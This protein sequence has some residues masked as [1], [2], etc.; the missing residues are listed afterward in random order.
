VRIIYEI[1]LSRTMAHLRVTLPRADSKLDKEKETRKD[2]KEKVGIM[3]V[4][5]KSLHK[6]GNITFADTLRD[7]MFDHTKISF[8]FIYEN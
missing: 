8:E 5:Y 6:L 1:N 4:Y 3:A 2:F 7:W